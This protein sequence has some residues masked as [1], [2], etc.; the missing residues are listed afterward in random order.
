MGTAHIC[1]PISRKPSSRKAAKAVPGMVTYPKASAIW[2]YIKINIKE[3]VNEAKKKVM[4]HR[5]EEKIHPRK[6]VPLERSRRK[7]SL[8]GHTRGSF[9]G[10]P[11][12]QM[13]KE[14]CRHVL[15]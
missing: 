3:K 7:V 9:G 15:S 8:K 11:G 14:C 4:A 2:N 12:T 13:V 10:G 1:W 5:Q 6:D